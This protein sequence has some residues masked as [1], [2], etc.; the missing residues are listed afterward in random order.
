MGSKVG[1]LRYADRLD[2]LLLLFGTMGCIGE[3][4][5]IPITMLVLSDEISNYGTAASAQNTLSI[6]VVDK[7]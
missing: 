2:K 1:P 3:G 5:M 6:P 4:M 7:V